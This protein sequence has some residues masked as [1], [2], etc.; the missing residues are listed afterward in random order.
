MTHTSSAHLL[1]A[2]AYYIIGAVLLYTALRLWLTHTINRAFLL[3]PY[4]TEAGAR[5]LLNHWWLVLAFAAFILSCAFEHHADWLLSR[6]WWPS[7]ITP[8][9]VLVL[10]QVE[11]IVSLVTAFLVLLLRLRA[12]RKV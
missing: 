11:M 5:L 6:G 9:T 12:W 2:V 8:Q 7:V 1:T 10:S 3:G 4:L